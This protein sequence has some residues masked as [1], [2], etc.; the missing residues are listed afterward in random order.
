MNDVFLSA[1]HLAKRYGGVIALDDVD[2]TVRRGEVHGLVGEN[3]SGKSTLVKII[4][5]V[6]SPEA[7]AEI[8]IAGERVRLLTPYDALRRGV[9]VVH[10]DVSLFPNLSVAENIAIVR[11][12]EHG[13]SPVRWGTVRGIAREALRKIDSDLP[14]DLP[15][16]SLPV[17]D[18]QLVA[19]SRA[20]AS[21]AR[22]LIMDEPTSALTRQE[23]GR[24]FRLIGDL[25]DRGIATL[26]IS[27]RL[28]EVLEI[29]E[30]V[31]VLKDGRK[32]GTFD[33]GAL[34]RGTL[35]RLMTGKEITYTRFRPRLDSQP[36]VLEVR[37]L[38]KAG[39]Y[40]DVSFA[41]HRGEVLGLIGPLGSGRTE[42]ALSL[43]GMNPPDTG[44]IYIDGAPARLASN[45]DAIRHGIAYVP[46]DRL[47]QGLVINQSVGNNLVITAFSQL[48]GRFRLIDG[49]RRTQ[50][51]ETAVRKFD[52]R[53]PS[54]EAPAR[55]LSGG[56]QQKVVIAKW[57][58]TRPRIL[59][60][61]GPTIGIDV[62]ARS[63]IYEIIQDLAR[64]GVSVLLI[65][66]E[67]GEVLSNCGRILLMKKGRIAAEFKSDEITEEELQRRMAD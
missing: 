23:V 61:D 48:L 42:L 18:Q 13:R 46:E 67:A 5:G 6:V 60:L 7:G 41:L 63:A 29:S 26:F 64:D 19:V 54:L 62:A 31:T 33:R 37:H 55:A 35:V 9:Q 12:V 51:C 58:S 15:A 14:L 21:D 57:L 52:I 1:R 8:E 65:S 44:A 10:Q 50:Y 28:D 11:Y 2:L 27:H 49:K 20:L 38:S 25:R 59:I 39:N 3:G 17:A 47:R 4:T 56:N 43:F 32:V 40:A 36:L 66:E 30:R 22:L 24:L 53:T 16:G 34:D 45:G